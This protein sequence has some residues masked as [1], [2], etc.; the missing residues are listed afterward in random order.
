MK[1]PN[2]SICNLS[3]ANYLQYWIYAFILLHVL[4]WTIAPTLVRHT[5]PMDAMEG[6]TWGHQLE[7]G[8]DKNPFMN[9]WL[10]ALAVHIGGQSG[11]AI[12]LLGQL[13]VALCFWSVWQLGKAILPPVYAF[14]AIFLLAS[15]QY[16]NLHAIDFNDNTLELGLWGATILFFYRALCHDQLKD[17]LL[18]GILAGLCMMTKYYA[19][20]L[21][22]PMLLFMLLY[23]QTRSY[24]KKSKLYLSLLIFLIII[25]PHT[26]WL[27]FHHFVTINYAL[28]R[29]S[30]EPTWWNHVIFPARFAWE[31]FEVFLPALFLSLILFIR[32]SPAT[33]H[34]NSF[35][36]RFLIIVGLGPFLLTLLLSALTG[37]QL[38]AGWGQPLLTFWGLA[39]LAWFKP[40]ITRKRFIIFVMASLTLFIAV[41]MGY[42][43]LLLNAKKPSSANF[44]GKNIAMAMT[45]TWHDQHHTPLT[46]VVGARWLAGNISF[47]SADHPQVYIDANPDFS[48]WINEKELEQKGALFV[49]DPTE[50]RQVTYEEMKKRFP[51]L[52]KPTVMHFD[53]LRN[54]S[55]TPV[56]ISVAILPPNTQ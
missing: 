55:M 46:Y 37:I 40:I 50:D 7:W 39:L 13:S 6:T 9:A 32:N 47:Y 41:V 28:H 4:V 49:W 22:L 24:F 45:Q 44:P 31:Q 8:Y 43:F 27:F 52:K 20:M 17:W 3:T 26:L 51:H 5:L 16:Y 19:A 34:M 48:P 25:T 12:Y 2:K 15:T 1:I 11:W 38:R 33:W 36:M 54:K 18:V 56:E 53:W 10:T 14:I 21:F 23:P 29:V 35:N 42:C 30:S